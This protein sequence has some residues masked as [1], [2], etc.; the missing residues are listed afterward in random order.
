M[1]DAQPPSSDNAALAAD[2]PYAR[3]AQTFPK[4]ESEQLERLCRYGE[5]IECA[6]GDMLF[7]RG[8]RSVDFFVV[9]RGSVE[10]FDIRTDGEANV[11]TTHRTHQFTG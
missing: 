1:S 11:F 9:K 8:E 7:E 10:I 4:L 6:K 3:E 2:D 5:Q